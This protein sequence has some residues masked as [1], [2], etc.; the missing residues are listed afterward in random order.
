[1]NVQK[2]TAGL[3]AGVLAFAGCAVCPAGFDT[4][5]IASAETNGTYQSLNY[6]LYDDHVTITG[7]DNSVA[8]LEIPAKIEGVPVTE[9]G[10]SA[11]SGATRLKSLTM[12][13]TITTIGESAF[14][15]CTALETLKLSESLKTISAY[16]FQKCTSIKELVL[17][18]SVSTI[19]ERAFQYCSSLEEIHLSKYLD[20]IESWAFYSCG[21]LT[22]LDF[23]EGMK[24]SGQNIC[25][26]CTNL[27][28]VN[29]ANGP[30]EI[31]YGAFEGCTSLEELY[32]PISVTKIGADSLYRTSIKNVYYAG[33]PSQ[34]AAINNSTTDYLRN[35]TIHY[36]QPNPPKKVT[37]DVNADGTINA[38][39]AALI[40]IYAAYVGAG[41]TDDIATYLSS[42]K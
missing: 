6:T 36:G 32:I 33:S 15:D 39:D 12:P 11:F 25:E 13:D 14:A 7:F 22:E 21:A 2:I 42:R 16:S 24:N 35:A 10:K 34:W 5:I 1:M 9:I 28:S 3:L 40:L 8:T 30:S 29:Y 26:N 18:D 17:P 31:A 27:R 37:A 20:H 41:G 4:A 23:P 38:S 19:G